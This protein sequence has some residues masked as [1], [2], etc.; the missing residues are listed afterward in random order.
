MLDWQVRV[1]NEKAELDEKL[2]ALHEF[3]DHAKFRDLAAIDQSLLREQARYMGEYSR[4]L[5]N[6]IARFAP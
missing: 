1:A 2:T 3:I 5:G 4:V 6:R